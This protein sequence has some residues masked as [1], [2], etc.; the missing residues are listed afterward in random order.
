MSV[1]I[2][3]KY[4]ICPPAV[5]L[6]SKLRPMS[7]TWTGIGHIDPEFVQTSSTSETTVFILG[8][9]LVKH[10]TLTISGQTN[11]QTEDKVQIS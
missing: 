11:G 8:Q 3:A 9:K 7:A 6:L 4:K 5:K 1:Q 2:T 10:W